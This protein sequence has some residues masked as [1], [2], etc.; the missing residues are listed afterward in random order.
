MSEPIHF[1][2]SEKDFD[3]TL[4]PKAGRE[5]GSPAFKK[6]VTKYFR[7]QY[8]NMDGETTVEFKNGNISVTWMPRSND[9]EPMD[10]I[11]DLLNTGRYD[12]AVPLLE[13]MLKVDPKNHDALYNLGMVYSDQGRLKEA[14]ELLGRA[15]AV[16]PDHANSFVALGVAS[17]RGRN[18]K[19]ARPALERAVELEPDNPFALRTLGT[20]YHMAGSLDDA[21]VMLRRAIDSSPNDAIALMAL[22][23][24]LIELDSKE[25]EIEA[26]DLLHRV[27]RISPH[28]DLAE[29]A[30]D[31]LRKIA[32]KNFRGNSVGE[33]RPDAV[34]YC[35]DAIKRFENM[36]QNELA[37]ILMEMAALGQSGL[38]VNDP[39][40]SF[41]LRS[42][43]GQF[44]ALQIVCM[45]HVGIKKIDP[46]QGSGFD[47][48]REY[49]S[50]V[51]MHQREL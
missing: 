45:M 19:E 42:L 37:P 5:I 15:T 33:L 51:A 13:T 30:K 50:A 22:A 3:L 9:L 34:M 43:P 44:S 32:S 17:L 23:Q 47:I 1:N 40:S 25:G 14:K 4:I 16:S 26:D 49:E 36:D 2:L 7:Q 46:S 39:E 6:H 11:L 20:L 35:L 41:S 38:P 18:Q 28:G 8:Q 21:V 31:A 24:C 48:E 29:K 10:A 27:L 12:Q